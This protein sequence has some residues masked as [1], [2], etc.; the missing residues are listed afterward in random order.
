MT[1]KK[2]TLPSLRS[3][4]WKNVKVETE[5]VNK[6]LP[7]IPMDNITELSELI[8]AGA[9]L[10]CDKIGVPQGNPN[11]NTRSRWEIRLEEQIKKLLLEVKMQ[12]KGKHIR[13]YWG[14]KSKIKQQISLKI[15]IKELNQK[16][17]AKENTK[18]R[19][20]NTNKTGYFKITKTNFTNKSAENALKQT[21]NPM[22]RKQENFEVN[23]GNRKNITE[24]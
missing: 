15:Q 5:K 13:I 18:R 24:R 3:Q 14:K 19:S 22:P 17:L 8:Y 2:I 16:I 6:L 1:E 12:K 21:N 10:V 23:Y 9:K 11:R 20:S 4:D 7:N